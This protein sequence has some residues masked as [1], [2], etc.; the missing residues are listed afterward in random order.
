ME[1]KTFLN[2]LLNIM[3]IL[4]FL[5]KPYLSLVFS[6][7]I[8]FVSC[9]QYDSNDE[10]KD[11]ELNFNKFESVKG[12]LLDINKIN[13]INLKTDSFSRLEQN[14]LILN[15][16]NDYYDSNIDFDE[17]L[18]KLNT[19]EEIFIWLKTNTNFNQNDI[20][21]LSEFSS[22]L[23]SLGFDDAVLILENKISNDNIDTYKF[24]KYQSIVNGVD[25][26]EYQYPGFFTT[27]TYHSDGDCAWAIFKLGLAAAALAGAC[28]PPALGASVG[29]TCYLAGVSFVA[30]SAS[31]GMACGDDD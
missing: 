23:T 19:T 17:S 16:V 12:Q 21:N 5:R 13:V 14:D 10:L 4:N 3:N 28:S 8:L 6:A 2:K 22:D 30:A 18:K 29:W 20:D 27:E 25:L 24:E 26:I 7:L 11:K 15:Q 1:R 31:V 9:E